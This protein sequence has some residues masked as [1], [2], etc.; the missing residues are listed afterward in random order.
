MWI[1][2]FEELNK[3]IYILLKPFIMVNRFV[4]FGYLIQVLASDVVRTHVVAISSQAP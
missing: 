1:I 2:F 4:L 3:G